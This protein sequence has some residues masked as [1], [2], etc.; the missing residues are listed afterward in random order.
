MP[1]HA[2]LHALDFTDL[3][4]AVAHLASLL[5]PAPA[6]PP[7]LSPP[8]APPP[9]PAGRLTAAKLCQ[10]VAALQPAEAVVVDESLTSGTAYWEASEAAPPFAHLAL[11]GGAIGQGPPCAVGAAVACPGRRVINFQADGS[12]LYTAQA[13]WTQAREKLAVTTVVCA[14]N[15]YGILKIELARQKPKHGGRGEAVEKLTNLQQPAIDWVQLAGGY[16]VPAVAVGTAE[17]FSREFSAALAADGPRVV[18]AML[19]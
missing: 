8:A 17:E 1:E 10:L 18:V 15:A 5:P 12:G 16:G 13:L 19:A 6:P 3:P 9:P 11:T 2:A 4:G 7:A 14:N